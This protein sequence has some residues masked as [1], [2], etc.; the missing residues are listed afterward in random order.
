MRPASQKQ[1]K[2]EKD[3]RG[4]QEKENQQIGR[5][6]VN[7]N[8]GKRN[9][10]RSNKVLKGSRYFRKGKS[11]KKG[12]KRDGGKKQHEPYESRE[13]WG[14]TIRINKKIPSQKTIRKKP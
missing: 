3:T 8:K 12:P 10:K 4:P 9:R 13:S 2:Q 11:T 5:N 6:T 7:K 1:G 14:R